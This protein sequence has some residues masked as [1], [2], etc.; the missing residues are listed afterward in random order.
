M[1]SLPLSRKVYLPGSSEDNWLV[2]ERDP[3]T[4]V[5]I[6]CKKIK[7]RDIDKNVVREAVRANNAII[8]HMEG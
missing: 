7:R 3:Q 8:R 6:N 2:C 4:E 5:L 1:M